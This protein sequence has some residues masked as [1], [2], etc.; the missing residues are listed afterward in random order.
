MRVPGL[1]SAPGCLAL[2]HVRRQPGL[3]GLGIGRRLLDRIN[4]PQLGA[5]ELALSMADPDTN[6][7]AYYNKRGYRFIEHWQWPYTN[8]RSCILSKTL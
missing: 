3:Q 2:R 7:R 5:Q 1:L 4:A 8:Y 6:L